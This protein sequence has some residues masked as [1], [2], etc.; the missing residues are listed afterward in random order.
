MPDI[1]VLEDR[2]VKALAA[3]ESKYARECAVSWKNALDE[4][5]VKMSK[6]YEKYAVD[7]VLTRAEMSKYNRYVTMEKQMVEITWESVT[8]TKA[9]VDRLRPDQY[10]ES[11]YRYA[12]T[13]DNSENI[14]VAWGVLNKDAVLENL[15][16][17]FY[18]ISKDTYGKN[19]VSSVRRALNDGLIAGKS[20]P[21]MVK[22]LKKSINATNKNLTR[23]IITEGQAAVNAGQDNTYT[24]AEQKGVDGARIWDSTLDGKTRPTGKKPAN[25]RVMDGQV[26]KDGVYQLRSTGET[27]PFPA[28]AGLSAGQRIRCRCHERFQVEGYPPQLRVSRDGGVIAYQPY[29][30]WDSDRRKALAK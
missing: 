19:A 3:R 10:N 24:R 27:A 2:T 16:N 26:R 28:Y 11:F 23:I 8:K 18:F 14:R 17:D 21:Q 22:D 30:E 1:R 13:I 29:D 20:Y 5:R 9:I 25:H 12:W 15:A 4:M 6:I 7:G